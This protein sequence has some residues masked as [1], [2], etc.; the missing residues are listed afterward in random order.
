MTS[1]TDRLDTPAACVLGNEIFDNE[2]GVNNAPGIDLLDEG[3]SSN[4]S[5]R[6]PTSCPR[7]PC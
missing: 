5:T 4:G 2:S 7:S 3:V 6:P 1:G